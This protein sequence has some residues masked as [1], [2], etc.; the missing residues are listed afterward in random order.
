VPSSVQYVFIKGMSYYPGYSFVYVPV[1]GPSG[2]CSDVLQPWDQTPTI[3]TCTQYAARNPTAEDIGTLCS[4]LGACGYC[5]DYCY[6]HGGA[7][8]GC[9][10]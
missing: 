2:T 4:L 9:P 10:Y 8:D 1:G 6:V 5:K 3:V 7:I